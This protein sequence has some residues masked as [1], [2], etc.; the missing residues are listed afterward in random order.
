[1][2]GKG[3]PAS[4]RS[5]RK[6]GGVRTTT[7]DNLLRAPQTPEGSRRKTEPLGKSGAGNRIRTGDP[8]LGTGFHRKSYH[9]QGCATLCNPGG[10][11]LGRRPAVPRKPPPFRGFCYARATEQEGRGCSRA[12]GL[13]HRPGGGAATRGLDCDGLQGVRSWRDALR[14][15][16]ER[17]ANT[18]RRAGRAAEGLII[19]P[20]PFEYPRAGLLVE[21]RT[22]PRWVG[23][24]NRDSRGPPSV[25]RPRPSW[26]ANGLS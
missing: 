8:Q 21:N 7:A 3:N 6:A 2:V 22:L 13:P 11:G 15:G 10:S 25:D 17:P 9:V 14:A 18:G 5:I 12:R 26:H 1:M 19:R 20:G 16:G 23:K 24:R 4:S